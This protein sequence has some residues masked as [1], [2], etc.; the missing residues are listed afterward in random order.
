MFAP[1]QGLDHAAGE[2]Q[3]NFLKKGGGVHT[4][5]HPADVSLISS[6]GMQIIDKNLILKD[7]GVVY[8]QDGLYNR[9]SDARRREM[10]GQ[11]EKGNEKV[12]DEILDFTGTLFK[13]ETIKAEEVVELWG[14]DLERIEKKML[15]LFFLKKT[16]TPRI[17]KY[18]K[19]ELPR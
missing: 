1:L 12:S 5:V 2:A 15:Q 18:A 3:H 17:V 8:H 10:I 11:L 7:G 19:V 14:G 4:G 9:T 6:A 16:T 13:L